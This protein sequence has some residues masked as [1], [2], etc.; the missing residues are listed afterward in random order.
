MSD[1][2]NSL[3]EARQL[4]ETLFAAGLEAVDPERA[5]ASVLAREGD[6]LLVDGSPV[7]MG[8]GL[9]LVAVGK[10]APAMALGAVSVLGDAIVAGD[11]ITKEG[12]ASGVLP[13]RFQEFEAGH[14]IPD[15]RGVDAARA[16]LQR[17]AALPDETIVLALISGGGSALLEAPR[18]GIALEDLAVTT[19]ALLH[20]GAPIDALNAV[21]SPLSRVKMG[22]LRAAAP[23]ARWVT[24]ILSDVLGNDPRVIASGPTIAAKADRGRALQ[25]IER[26]GVRGIVPPAV[27]ALLSDSE[28]ASPTDLGGDDILRIIGDNGVAMQ[29]VMTAANDRDLTSEIVWQQEQGEASA[30]GREFVR[31][32]PRV[33]DDIDLLIGGGE[34]TVTVRGT[35]QGGRNTEFALAAA[36]ELEARGLSEWIVA[37]LGTDGQDATTGFAGAIA[38]AMT[39]TRSREQGVD[40]ELAL[41]DN[42][43]LRVFEAAG[44]AVFTGPTGTNVNDLYLALRR[45]AQ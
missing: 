29:A 2:T 8:R 30:R 9:Y 11:V 20:A 16:V 15:Q 21:R 31:L 34:M 27:I 14:P 39:A 37:S 22:G 17:L 26:F 33:P 41:R 40:P 12:H 1:E 4:I 38:D 44:G 3:A 28:P 18:D 10:A 35:G 7:P 43:S 42:D 5:V 36:L 32:L 45:Q 23:R 25:T 24:L 13:E 19:G 6:A